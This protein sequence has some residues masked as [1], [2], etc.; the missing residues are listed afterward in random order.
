[1]MNGWWVPR[2]L[3]TLVWL[4]AVW[5]LLW[6][7]LTP[8]A[9]ASGVAVAA[10]IVVLFPLP[11]VSERLVV[12]PIPLLRLAGFVLSDVALSGVRVGWDALRYGGTVRTAI[13]AVEMLTDDDVP[14]AVAASLLTL[15][16]GTFVVAIDRTRGQYYVHALGTAGAS[17]VAQVRATARRLQRLVLRTFGARDDVETERGVSR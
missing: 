12:R 1:M 9:V 13:V 15:S 6:W 8:L 3:P 14:T 16:P 4:V 2:R 17:D 7:E 10:A 11:D 5:L